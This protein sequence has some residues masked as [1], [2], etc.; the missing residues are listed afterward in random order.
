MLG[1]VLEHCK[2]SDNGNYNRYHHHIT[3][4]LIYYFL[5][6]RQKYLNNSYLLQGAVITTFY[7]I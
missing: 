7:S 2:H 1:M 3:K 4:I 5:L 6:S